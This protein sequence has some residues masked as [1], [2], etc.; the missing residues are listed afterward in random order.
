MPK[1]PRTRPTLMPKM[2][3]IMID[4]AKVAPGAAPASAPGAAPDGRMRTNHI[5][6]LA[7]IYMVNKSLLIE[8]L[9][10]H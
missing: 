9:R 7:T 2:A 10:K 1:W 3:V 5:L 8:K 6:P 4:L